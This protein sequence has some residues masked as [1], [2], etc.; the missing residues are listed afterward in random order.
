M[1]NRIGLPPDVPALVENTIAL[2]LFRAYEPQEEQIRGLGD[3]SL[4]HV[5]RTRRD[6][7]TDFV[8]GSRKDFDVVEVKYRNR[9]DRRIITPMRQ[10]FP[11]RPII[12]ASKQEYAVL[13]EQTAILPAALLAWWLGCD[14]TQ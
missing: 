9:V 14:D 4:L 8:A 6:G 5:W 13:D 10:A 1:I 11:G 2:T 3:P 12:I 7:E